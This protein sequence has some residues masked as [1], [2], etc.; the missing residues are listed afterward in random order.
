MPFL[1]LGSAFFNFRANQLI[2]EDF[3]L[4]PERDVFESLGPEKKQDSFLPT[5]P[6]ELMQTLQGSS[7]MDGATSPKDALDEALQLFN[8]QDLEN[9][10]S[11]NN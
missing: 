10:S 6:M 4:T 9:N 5:T 7:A 11:M 8:Y 3:S 1:V 2:A